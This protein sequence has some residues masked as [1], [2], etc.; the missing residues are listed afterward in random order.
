MIGQRIFR[1]CPPEKFQEGAPQNFSRGALKMFWQTPV[2]A[3]T[4]G[5][6][7]VLV[8]GSSRGPV[9]VGRLAIA[10]NR[11]GHRD[12]QVTARPAHCQHFPESFSVH[13]SRKRFRKTGTMCRKC[14]RAHQLRN[15]KAGPLFCPHRN[16]GSTYEIDPGCTPTPSEINPP[17]PLRI[18]P[19]IRVRYGPGL[20]FRGVHFRNMCKKPYT[21]THIFQNRILRDIYAKRSVLHRILK[22]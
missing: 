10:R 15:R 1:K 16:P 6:G 22:R 4:R 14:R 8:V 20:P 18:P 2:P 19:P 9:S 5:A 3:R 21:F 7:R 17:G 13:F 11:N 12:V